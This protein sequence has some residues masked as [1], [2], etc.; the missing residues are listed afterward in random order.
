MKPPRFRKDPRFKQ[1]MYQPIH[2]EKFLGDYAV[3]RSGL[4]LKFMKF[5]DTNPNVLKW[6]SENV[7]IPYYS[8]IDKK[9]HRYFVDNFVMIKE[10]EIIKKYL[11]EVKPSRQTQPPT[12]KYKKKS[13]MIYEQVQWTVNQAK[14]SACK[15]VCK[16]RGF[17]FIILTEKDL[18]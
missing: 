1:G 12:A 17:E 14:W 7:V 2:K 10:G 3:Y 6:G 15:E 18:P 4:E 16:K 5:C 9:M 13:N 11:V 8:P